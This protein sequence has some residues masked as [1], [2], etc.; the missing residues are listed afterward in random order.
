MERLGEVGQAKQLCTCYYFSPP[1][2]T[3]GR[4][5]PEKSEGWVPKVIHV[6]KR[7]LNM[8]HFCS[9]SVPAIRAMAL[10]ASIFR[11]AAFV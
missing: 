4:L 5:H 11:R 10:S 7:A 1:L 8:D 3:T 6:R 9:I 2:G